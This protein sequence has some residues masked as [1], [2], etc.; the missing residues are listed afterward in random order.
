M[1]RT[2]GASFLLA[3][4]GLGETPHA[5]APETDSTCWGGRLRQVKSDVKTERGLGIGLLGGPESKLQCGLKE[6][7]CFQKGDT[8]PCPWPPCQVKRVW[9]WQ[10]SLS[11]NTGNRSSP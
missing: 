6:R 1:P 7:G 11:H 2:W 3:Q 5:M 8:C 9:G 10:L 4:Q